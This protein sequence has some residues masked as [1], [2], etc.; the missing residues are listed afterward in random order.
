MAV[1]FGCVINV[2]G[3]T[4]KEITNVLQVANVPF[5]FSVPFARNDRYIGRHAKHSSILDKLLG[6]GTGG[7]MHLAIWGLG[8]I[9]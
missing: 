8:G 9:G 4:I 1:T 7:Q 3:P 2:E 5:H 6:N